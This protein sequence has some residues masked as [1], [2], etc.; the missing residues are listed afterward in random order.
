[1]D[2]SYALLLAERAR[3]ALSLGGV[4]ARVRA[5]RVLCLTEPFRQA[6]GTAS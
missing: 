6:S 5:E 2:A 1:M 3:R 4:P